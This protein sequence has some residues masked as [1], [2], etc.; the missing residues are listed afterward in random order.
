MSLHGAETKKN[1]YEEKIYKKADNG[2]NCLL[3][4]AAE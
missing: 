1:N 4:E 2:I 3:E